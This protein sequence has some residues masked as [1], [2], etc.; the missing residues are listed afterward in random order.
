M[1]NHADANAPVRH[2]ETQRRILQWLEQHPDAG[3]TRTTIYIPVIFHVV[4]NNT[5]G[6]VPSTRLIEQLDVLNEDF[7]G[8]NSDYA[9][10]PAVWQP[11]SGNTDIQFCLAHVDP[12]GNWTNG[13][14]YYQT[15]ANLCNS[16]TIF[17]TAPGWNPNNYLNIWVAQ[18]SSGILGFASPLGSPPTQDGVVIMHEYVGK[19]GAVAPYNLGRTGTHEVGHWLGL[20]HIWGNDGGACSGSD[21]V[22]DTPN[23]ADNTFNC[24]PPNTVLTDA[25]S[26]AAPGIMWMN[27][28][29]YSDDACMYMFT[30]GQKALML[31]TINTVRP[32]L[33]TS[34]VCQVTGMRENDL[35]GQP[36]AFPSP[37]QGLLTVWM[38]DGQTEVK[39]VRI[40]NTTGALMEVIAAPS[41]SGNR[42][43][44]DLTT[45]PAGLYLIAIETPETRFMLRAMRN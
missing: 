19:T 9:N 6:N 29:D 42:F 34:T 14:Q 39:Y 20:A 23:Q 44:L 41:T 5:Q 40:Y 22:A 21:N 4:Y 18:C 13:Y 36:Q 33:L 2:A 3:N 24:R 43:E 25:C 28:M 45:Y 15:S 16:S 31:A 38:P 32:G 7:G 17:S 26:P 8:Y 11:I 27:Y 35:S 10:T 30:Q 37:T 1:H 12:Q